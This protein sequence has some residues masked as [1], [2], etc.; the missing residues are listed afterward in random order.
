MKTITATNAREN[1]YRLIDE[2]AESSHPVQI[3]GRRASAVLISADDWRSIEE[4]LYLMSVPGMADSIVEAM[5]AGDD[6]YADEPG[7]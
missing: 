6:E 4:T 2:V 3:M 5:A 7:W 1:L